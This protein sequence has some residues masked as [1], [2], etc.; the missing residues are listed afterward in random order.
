MRIV[1][2]IGALALTSAV[3]VS[4]QA[5]VLSAPNVNLRLNEVN[6]A[7]AIQVI[8]SAGGITIELDESVPAEV[9][10]RQVAMVNFRDATMDSVL[11]FVTERSGLTFVVVDAKTVR[12][13]MQ[14]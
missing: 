1:R 6:F 3:M 10:T 5:P 9:R 12:I 11:R 13:Q 2:Y 7:E 4:A 8:A 14:R